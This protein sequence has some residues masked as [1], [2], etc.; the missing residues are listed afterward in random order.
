[1]RS[2]SRPSQDSP[3]PRRRRYSSSS[4]RSVRW[5]RGILVRDVLPVRGR[6]SGLADL[7][8]L[9]G[10]LVCLLRRP[11]KKKSRN[12]LT[13]PHV[14]QVRPSR[15]LRDFR[16]EDGLLWGYSSLLSLVCLLLSDDSR[17]F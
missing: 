13:C 1:M 7:L 4:P 16:V 17:V 6:G 11:R 14:V 12:G 10:H 15:E 5:G 8:V 3:T 9:I 2:S